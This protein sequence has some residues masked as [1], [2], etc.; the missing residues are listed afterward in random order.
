[1]HKTVW[2]R[3]RAISGM[4]QMPWTG[5][6][7]KDIDMNV[8]EKLFGK[9]PEEDL[10][11]LAK[12]KKIC[13]LGYHNVEFASLKDAVRYFKKDGYGLE[14]RVPEM[15]QYNI[16]Y[17]DYL[18]ENGLE[19]LL[20]RIISDVPEL[21]K[22]EKTIQSIIEWYGREGKK[23]AGYDIQC[24]N[25]KETITVLGHEFHGLEDVIAHRTAYGRIGYSDLS[26]NRCI[27]KK[28]KSGLDVSEFYASYP[29]FDSYDIGDDR[30][31]QNYVFTNKPIDDEKLKE[32]AEIRHN[33]NYC[34]VH[35]NIPEHLLPILY[36]RGDGDYMIL[37]QK[38]RGI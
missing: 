13:Y 10:P 11:K 16:C 27:P 31:Y 2:A 18:R 4:Q 37:A 19:N 21:V 36:Y 1:M 26:I 17:R 5:N 22:E 8:I 3:W 24:Y 25:I 12:Q 29:I 23:L 33:Y 30:T 28:H 32:I 34:M 20:K 9:R 15:L 6:N 7:L 14:Y 38:K 35:E